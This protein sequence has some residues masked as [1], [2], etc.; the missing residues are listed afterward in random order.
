LLTHEGDQ[1]AGAD[2]ADARDMT[3]AVVQVTIAWSNGMVT[4]LP[5]EASAAPEPDPRA[6]RPQHDPFYLG[7]LAAYASLL[8]AAEPRRSV[9]PAKRL[10]KQ[11]LAPP[12]G[13]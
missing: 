4:S 6:A 11:E 12:H 7:L 10:A 3:P 5:E 9:R 8:A 13:S 2:D 1:T